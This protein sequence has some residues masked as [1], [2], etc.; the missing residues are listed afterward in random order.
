MYIN[1]WTEYEVKLYLYWWLYLSRSC[2]QR[3]RQGP[4]NTCD[5]S[6]LTSFPLNP[7]ALGQYVNNQSR[8]KHQQTPDSYCNTGRKCKRVTGTCLMHR[9]SHGHL[10]LRCIVLWIQFAPWN[11]FPTDDQFP[12]ANTRFYFYK[13]NY[14]HFPFL[15]PYTRY[16][17]SGDILKNINW[18]FISTCLA[19][20]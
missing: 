3:D 6:W 20:V 16:I 1:S 17:T 4:F 15:R 11:I 7:L 14:C 8:G 19:N 9:P 12:A 10:L 18:Y 13:I 2:S 5:A